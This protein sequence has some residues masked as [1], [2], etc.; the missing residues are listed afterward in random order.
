MMASIKSSSSI[1]RRIWLSPLVVLPENSGFYLELDTV[2]GAFDSDFDFHT[3]GAHYECGDG[4]CKIK[5]SGMS[6]D[7]SI[8]KGIKP[9]ENCNH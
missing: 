5:V 1:Q 7:V 3:M 8:L 9:A 2:S 4:A 6:G